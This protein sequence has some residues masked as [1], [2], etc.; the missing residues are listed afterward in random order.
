MLKYLDVTTVAVTIGSYPLSWI[1]LVGTVLYFLSVWLIARK[2][3][4]TWPVGIVSVVL[5]GIL[6]YQVRLYSDTIEQ[7]YYLGV[8]VYGWIAWKKTR[9][10]SPVVRSAFSPVAA[11]VAWAGATLVMAFA[12]GLAV[13]RLHLWLPRL[14]P[15]PAS[16]PFLDALTTVMS[17][18]A[19]FLMSRR[20]TESWIYWII[21][22]V[23][24][25]GLYWVKGVR[26]ISVQYVV[27]LGM[28]IYGLVHWLGTG[29]G[30]SRPAEAVG[31]GQSPV[32]GG[33]A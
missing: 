25:I 14:F 1:E 4:L 13:A 7:L 9:D 6:F 24:G 20:R 21:V 31:A 2:N 8:S 11:A 17:F 32:G 26:F 15:E 5:Y 33:Q 27:L 12:A 28:A 19:M 30:R 16:F 10:T 22:D 18:V 3:M 29:R 23:I